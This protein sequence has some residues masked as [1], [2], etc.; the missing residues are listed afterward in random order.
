VRQIVSDL[1]GLLAAGQVE[2]VKSALS[3]LITRIEVHEVPRPGKKRPGAKLVVRGNL[4]AVL[5]VTGKFTSVGS[6]EGIRTPDLMAENHASLAAR[7]RGHAVRGRVYGARA[8]ASRP[9]GD[10]CLAPRTNG[11][12]GA[13]ART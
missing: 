6:P 2:R 4:E 13:R 3:R 7:R 8:C 10:A 1:R 12:C 11:G 5:E 9:L